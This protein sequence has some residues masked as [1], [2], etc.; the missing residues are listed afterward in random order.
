MTGPEPS[1]TLKEE[2]DRIPTAL[3]PTIEMSQANEEVPLFEGDISIGGKGPAVLSGRLVLRWLPSPGVILEIPD[4]PWNPFYFDRDFFEPIA[5]DVPDLGVS[6]DAQ[7]LSVGSNGMVAIMRR[8]SGGKDTPVDALTFEIANGPELLGSAIRQGTSAWDGRQVLRFDPWEMTIDELSLEPEERKELTTS[9]GYRLTHTCRLVSKGGPFTIREAEPT[10]DAL[11][12]LLSFIRGARTSPILL[13][14]WQHERRVALEWQRWVIQEW[15][16]R[17]TWCPRHARTIMQDM[18]PAVINLLGDREWHT[19]LPLAIDFYLRANNVGEIE[20]SML[21]CHA[22]LEL[23]AWMVFVVNLGQLRSNAFE[24]LSAS[25]HLRLLLGWARIPAA[26]P[27]L[28]EGLRG[29]F[30]QADSDGPYAF[31]ELRN[32]IVHPRKRERM[33]DISLSAKVEAVQL[34][35]HYLEL[36]LLKLLGYSGEIQNRLHRARWASETEPVPW[37]NPTE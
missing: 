20:T 25:D 26:L 5:I 14:G 28:C 35:V 1:R 15:V 36:A 3:A 30:S 24:R 9:R 6:G 11:A 13:S 10:I 17:D 19:A 21:L 18:F 29:A 12:W 32:A 23:M 34:G 27:A 37:A 22:G 2:I 7:P 16:S 8:F 33:P 31:T 4:L